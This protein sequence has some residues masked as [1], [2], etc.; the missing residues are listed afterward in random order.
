MPNIVSLVRL[1]AREEAAIRAVDKTIT[2]GHYGGWFNGEYRETWPD[3]TVR[4]YVKGDGTGT[5][6]ER[7]LI[8]QQADIVIG[9]FPYPLD[10]RTRAPR[11]DWLHQT[12]AGASNLRRGDIWGSD[13]TVTTSRGYGETTAIA[14]Y[15]LAGVFHFAKGLDHA[16]L[17]QKGGTFDYSRYRVCSIEGKTLCVVGA[18]GIGREV[19]RL[20]KALGMRTLGIRSASPGIAS[21]AEFDGIGGPEQL[22]DFL[23]QCDFVVVSCQWTEATTNLLDDEVF[24]A[25]K[26]QAVIVN[27]A[28]GEIIDE[29]A[30]LRALDSGHI[31]G[32]LLD[33][34]VGEF[35]GAPPP[36]LW[37]HPRVVITPHTSGH[38]DA[39]RRRSTELFCA[40]LRRYLNNETLENKVDWSL[41][42]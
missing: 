13:V 10:L 19:A 1:N 5:R 41:G 31:R 6:A 20:S 26:D 2:L 16:Y 3:K 7:D 15:A 40:N 27:V 37:S 11:L 33:V 36:V 4:R 24:A 34:Y 38:T 21:D 12:P 17:D 35:E 14:E 18:G 22:N 42:Y 32:A 25:M 9:G 28:R 30:L 23:A 29:A 39:S 8:L